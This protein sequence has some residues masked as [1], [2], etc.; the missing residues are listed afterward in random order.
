MCYLILTTTHKATRQGGEDQATGREEK[1]MIRHETYIAAL[2]WFGWK[3]AKA[4]Q[5]VSDYASAGTL[6]KLDH[7]VRQYKLHAK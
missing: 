6:D 4:R 5:I 3:E 7:L 2:R 1:K